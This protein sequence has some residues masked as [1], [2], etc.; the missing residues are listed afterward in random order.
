MTAC[1]KY[2]LYRSGF[3][4]VLNSESSSISF[5]VDQAVLKE[6]VSVLLQFDVKREISHFWHHFYLESLLNFT[7]LL[8]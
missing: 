4:L 8:R 2:A 7:E 6:K 3:R 5:S 1:Q